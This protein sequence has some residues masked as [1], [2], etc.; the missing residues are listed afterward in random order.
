MSELSRRGFLELTGA[1][2][3]ATPSTRPNILFLMADQFRYDCLG[4]N[5]N[6][7]VRPVARGTVITREMVAAPTDSPLWALRARQDACFFPSL[8]PESSP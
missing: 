2:A 4:A 8:R 3:A 7:L 5:G 6:R 1:A